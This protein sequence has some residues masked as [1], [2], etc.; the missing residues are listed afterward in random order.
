MK[1][2]VEK[3]ETF[4]FVADKDYKSGDVVIVGDLVGIAVTDAKT[5]DESVAHACGVY[6]LPKSAGAIG[7]GAKVYWVT[8]D[9]NISTTASGNTL[10]GRAWAAQQAADP[11]VD[12]KL[13]PKN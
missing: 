3:G 2:F 10:I 9:S 1:N 13:T 7:Q 8:A 12:V 5:G 6:R 11:T 4:R